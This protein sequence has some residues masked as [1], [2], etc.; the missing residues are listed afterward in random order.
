[1]SA[2]RAV[3]RFAA[4]VTRGVAYHNMGR[5]CY[6]KY[7]CSA[8]NILTVATL[9]H[10]RPALSD[11]S[12][13]KWRH[14]EADI[15]LCTVLWYL[16]YALSCRDAEELL[17]HEFLQHNPSKHINA[18]TPLRNPVADGNPRIPAR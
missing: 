12:L 13:F 14:F 11:P 17:P 7:R 16:R 9:D 5:F 6:K 1:M 3:T 10:R 2:A 8:T 15:I 18:F 4:R